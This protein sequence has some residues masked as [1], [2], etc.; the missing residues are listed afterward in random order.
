MHIHTHKHM[1][2]HILNSSGTRVKDG[3]WYHVAQHVEWSSLSKQV[4]HK[5][6]YLNACSPVGG[7]IWGGL[8]TVLLEEICYWDRLECS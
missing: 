7:S 2:T 4:P 5:L 8:S 6:R 3:C 1:H